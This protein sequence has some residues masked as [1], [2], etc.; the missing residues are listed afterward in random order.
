MFDTSHKTTKIEYY[1]HTRVRGPTLAQS[2]TLLEDSAVL[3]SLSICNMCYVYPYSGGC[4]CVIVLIELN[5]T[6]NSQV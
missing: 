3:V 6:D 1:S 5:V 2:H 4:D